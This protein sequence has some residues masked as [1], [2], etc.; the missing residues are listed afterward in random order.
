MAHA[1]AYLA[2]G[3]VA[4]L[5]QQ[6]LALP[7]ALRAQPGVC[8][9]LGC[10]ELASHPAA[11]LQH[12][13]LARQGFENAGD[14][15]GAFQAAAAAA[16][17]IVDLGA[18]LHALDDWMPLLLAHAA[19][20]LARPDDEADLRVLPGLL[21]AYVHRATAHPLTAEL[22]VRAERLLDRP[23]GPGQRILLGTLAFYLL[24]D[25]ADA[26]ARPHHPQDRP[27]V[28]GFGCGRGHAAA[29]VRRV[30]AGAGAAG[31]CRRSAGSTHSRP[32]RWRPRGRAPMRAKAHLLLVLAAVAGRDRTLAASELAEAGSA[33]GCRPDHRRHHLRI[34]A[35]PADDA[36]QRLVGRRP[37]DARGR[38]QR[39]CQR[40]AAARAHRP[41]GADAGGHAG[42]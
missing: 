40:L 42:G 33:A 13:Q 19:E 11:A 18:N 38:G 1:S 39:P 30:G 16:D 6:L 9:W 23:I 22:A 21:A 29:L 27:A 5:R 7:E 15:H 10:C 3:R 26:A 35:R 4:L 8:Y 24:W 41:A 28:R 12:L 17:A 2:Q 37:P 25:R 32:C 31:P 20:H 14:H 36:G 34:P